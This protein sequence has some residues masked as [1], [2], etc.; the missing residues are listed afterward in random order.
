MSSGACEYCPHR[1]CLAIIGTARPHLQHHCGLVRYCSAHILRNVREHRGTTTTPTLEKNFH[2][3]MFWRLQGSRSADEYAVYL[4]AFEGKF[5]RTK[6][7]LQAIDPKRWV[8]YAQIENGA[9]TWGWRTSNAGEIGQGSFLG[10]LRK[11]H[12]LDFFSGLQVK[13][14][15]SLTLSDPHCAVP[16]APCTPPTP[17]TYP[18]TP[19]HTHTHT[20]HTLS[21]HP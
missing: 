15:T 8:R 20:T 19:T 11:A 2:D 5:P 1:C 12:P 16:P 6:A 4:A 21:A 7:Y 17:S 3:N 14:V 9:S 10:D 13:V 18:P